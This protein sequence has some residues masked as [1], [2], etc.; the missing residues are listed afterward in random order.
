MLMISV[1]NYGCS[2]V[3]SRNVFKQCSISAL[4]IEGQGTLN[5]SEDQTIH[6]HH[7]KRPGHPTEGYVA[8]R[9]SEDP[10]IRY[11]LGPFSIHENLTLVFLLPST[12]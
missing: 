10:I 1:S 2:A 7:N 4:V 11:L 9:A 8:V 3:P 5:L 6:H 12:T